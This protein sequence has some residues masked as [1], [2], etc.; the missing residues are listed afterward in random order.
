VSHSTAPH[1][2]PQGPLEQ[3][4]AEALDALE[5]ALAGGRLEHAVVLVKTSGLPGPRDAASCS[6]GLAD[7]RELFAEVVAYGAAIAES[8]GLDF[9]VHPLRR[10]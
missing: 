9:H 4:V 10:G 8:L 2:T 6:R 1:D 3:A 7:A 5:Q